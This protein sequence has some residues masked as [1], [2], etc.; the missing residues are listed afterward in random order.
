[1]STEK[2][3][4][5]VSQ[6]ASGIHECGEKREVM[7]PN[8]LLRYMSP[9]KKEVMYPIKLLRYMSAEEKGKSCIPTG[10]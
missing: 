2:K 10:S 8:W 7:Y 3:G 6:Q 1:M 9:E 4:S 5:H